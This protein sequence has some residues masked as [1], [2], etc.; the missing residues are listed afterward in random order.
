[1]EPPPPPTDS[2]DTTGPKAADWYR[3]WMGLIL[4]AV[5]FVGAQLWGGSDRAEHGRKID[6]QGNDIAEMKAT[7]NELRDSRGAPPPPERR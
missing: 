3:P 2:P 1:M 4:W 7:L 5:L 6:K